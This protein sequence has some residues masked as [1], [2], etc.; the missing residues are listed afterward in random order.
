LVNQK[1]AGLND[2]EGIFFLLLKICLPI[3]Q[4]TLNSE[5]TNIAQN[6]SIYIISWARFYFLCFFMKKYTV[7]IQDHSAMRGFKIKLQNTT[8]KPTQDERACIRG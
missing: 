7:K 2:V 8:L 4:T 3:A 6:H 5:S 1:I